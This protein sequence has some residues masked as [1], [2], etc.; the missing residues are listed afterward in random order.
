MSRFQMGSFLN[1]QKVLRNKYF[2]IF[3]FTFIQF[4]QRDVTEKRIT[5]LKSLFWIKALFWIITVQRHFFPK[6]GAKFKNDSKIASTRSF[7]WQDRIKLQSNQFAKQKSV[8]SL[9]FRPLVSTLSAIYTH[10]DRT[11]PPSFRNVLEFHGH[12]RVWRSKF[13]TTIGIHAKS[14][15]LARCALSIRIGNV[16]LLRQ[17]PEFFFSD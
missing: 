12:I 13:A 6:N 9:L 17:F 1:H 5:N 4:L 11:V 8:C 7:D 15:R 16:K 14:R 3:L 10:F 2:W